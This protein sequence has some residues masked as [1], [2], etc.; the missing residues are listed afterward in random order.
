MRVIAKR[1]MVHG[2]GGIK[3]HREVPARIAVDTNQEVLRP[4]A[5]LAKF[6]RA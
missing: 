4:I 5:S 6:L 3:T 2:L 1:T